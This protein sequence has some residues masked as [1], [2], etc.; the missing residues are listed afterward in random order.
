MTASKYVPLHPPATFGYIGSSIELDIIDPDR[1]GVIAGT[2][3][4]TGVTAPGFA[5]HPV[6]RLHVGWTT[7]GP[8]YE[9]GWYVLVDGQFVQTDA[10]YEQEFNE[11]RY[12]LPKVAVQKG[13][14][15]RK[16]E[17]PC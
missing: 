5:E 17:Q 12:G 16:G 6:Y 13:K 4:R 7:E 14:R 11:G 1:R 8:R 15:K 10:W 3:R 2:A 9:P